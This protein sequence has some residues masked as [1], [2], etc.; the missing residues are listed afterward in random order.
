[1]SHI[2]HKKKKRQG[3]TREQRRDPHHT[4]GLG[5]W[6]LVCLLATGLGYG[7]YSAD[8]Q[9][10]ADKVAH[11]A[12]RPVSKVSVEGDFHFVARDKVQHL[13]EQK[14]TGN[15]VDID[16]AE[17][18][19]A[20]EHNPWVEKVNIHRI[21]PDSLSVTILEQHPIARWGQKGF[22]NREGKLILSPLNGRLKHLPLLSG[23][24]DKSGDVA[25]KYLEVS[26]VLSSSGLNVAGLDV[27]EK[28]SWTVTLK[29]AIKLVLGQENIQEKLKNFI[30]VYEKQLKSIM[31]TVELVDM[32]YENGIAVRWVGE[33]HSLVAKQ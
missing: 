11:S 9:G 23:R 4:R 27:D 28:M 24:D 25:K 12:Q 19:A 29:P 8:W 5:R 1:M 20:I 33:Q 32:R 14:I 3:A 13:L 26:K 6:F 18:K 17:V 31:N 2:E 22:L 10:L 21:W 15:F 7:L 16:L 30:L